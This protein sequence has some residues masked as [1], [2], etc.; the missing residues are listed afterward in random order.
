M[1]EKK[2][3]GLLGK[4]LNHS[5]SKTYFEKEYP[6]LYHNPAEYLNYELQNLDNLHS[7]ILSQHLD[8][9][10]ITIPFK[11]QILPLLTHL[12]PE[13]K[14]IEAVNCVKITQIQNQLILKGFNTDALAF[15]TSILPL[16]KN[17]RN[18][19]IFG[20]GGAAKAVNYALQKHK[21]HTTFVSRSKTSPN[22]IKYNDL[23]PQILHHNTLIIN[24]TP[25]GTLG[26][27]TEELP[28]DFSLLNSSHLCYDLVYNPGT[29]PF[30]QHAKNQSCTTKNGLEMLHLQALKSWEIWNN[31]N[32]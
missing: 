29:T 23:T 16:L 27:A 30:L 6:T 3:F 1:L 25:V 10:N 8:G 7:L 20:T 21:V 11:E 14:I 12:S 4:T 32:L 19:L 5:L 9:L 28:I 17:H 26:F 2:H 31:G 22:T 13:A 24:A 15:E 18:A